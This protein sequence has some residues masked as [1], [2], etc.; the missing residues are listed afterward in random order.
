MFIYQYVKLDASKQ[1]GLH[2]QSSYELS[3]IIKGNGM[4]QIGDISEPFNAGEIVLVA[5]D[6]PHCWRFY[7]GGKIVNATI[8]FDRDFL[9]SCAN[10][11]AEF[12][13]V[14]DE[15]KK[16]SSGAVIFDSAKTVDM[17]S[18]ISEMQHED[19]ATR[20]ASMLRLMP[21]IAN[22]SDY[23]VIGFTAVDA[24]KERLESIYSYVAC[25]IQRGIS[26]AD[27]ADHVGMNRS[28]FCSFFKRSVGVSFVTYLNR[29][30]I[31]RACQLLGSCQLSIAEI[32]YL[33]GFNDVPY[34]NRLFK[35]T[36]AITPREYK[37][38]HH[39]DDQ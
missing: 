19:D 12:A 31:E 30:R 32:C 25:N 9:S 2:S 23:S 14:V 20:I 4:R 28:S 18:I 8:F 6:T 5:P 3:Y 15:I 17:R 38:R 24:D 13:P 29:I 35:K 21:I 7:D 11:F 34:F 10:A 26:L 1:I 33:S 39:N 36:M 27:I 22:D 16:I 37:L